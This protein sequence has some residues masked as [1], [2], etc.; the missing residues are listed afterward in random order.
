VGLGARAQT[1]LRVFAGV[2]VLGMAL[3]AAHLGVGL[4]GDGLDSLFNHFVYNG[5]L[6]SAVAACLLRSA[7]VREERLPWLLMGIGLLSWLAGDLYWTFVLADMESPPYPSPADFLYLGFYPAS[8]VA[9]V[10]LLRSR[11]ASF[12]RSLWLDGAIGALGVSA[13]AAALAFKPILDATSGNIAAVVTNLAYPIGDLTLLALTV[14]VFGLSGWRPGRAWLM[15]GAGLTLLA[16]ADGIYLVQAAKDTY[17]EG[18]LLDALWPAATLLVGWSAWQPARMGTA[19][20][21]GGARV[22][23]VP[24]VSA[25][26][27]VGLLTYDHFQR[28]STVGLV[29]AS[30]TLLAVTVRMTMTFMEN[31]RMLARSRHEALTDGLTGLRNRRSLMTDLEREVPAA[32][33]ADPC[34]VIVFDLDGFKM[35]NDSFGHPAGDALLARLGRRLGEAIK[36]YGTA[37]RM[38]GDEFCALVRPESG[39]LEQIAAAASAALR[40]HGEGFEVASSHGVVVVPTE[41]LNA[42][43]ALQ[44][45]DRRMFA[46]KGGRRS[47]AGRQSRDVLL[48]TLRERQPDLHEH[49]HDVAEL[50]LAIGRSY[51]MTPEELD[52]L[53]RAAELHDVGKVAIPDE[54]LSKPG[55]L[56]EAEWAFMRRHTIIGERILMAAPALRPVAGTVRSSHERW[57]GSGYPDGLAGEKIPLAARIV[58]VCDAFHAMISERPYRPAMTQEDALEELRSCA[59]T[60]FDERVVETFC[61]VVTAGGPVATVALRPE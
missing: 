21:I 14:A 2:A 58:C 17:V 20:T 36:P 48:H 11:V 54:I 3:Y 53:A 56:D 61:Q 44:L 1:I 40:E 57:D 49:L 41:T 45:A 19:P 10:L 43:Q 34:A 29:L 55:P 52:V 22:V 35:Y 9:L 5:L 28:L 42:S 33:P 47:S 39:G 8:Y 50:A 37:Y 51:D 13:I 30:A 7:L 24:L 60:Q 26:L 31:Q 23:A 6:I 4:G 38:G 25:L 59:G 16:V 15:L 46:E 18:T 12:R 27:A 32:T